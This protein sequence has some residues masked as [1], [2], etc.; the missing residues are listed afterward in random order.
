RRIRA[1][2]LGALPVPIVAMTADARVETKSRCLEAGMDDFVTKPIRRDDVEGIL[3]RWLPESVAPAHQPRTKAGPAAPERAIIDPD[4]IEALRQFGPSHGSAFV[5]SCIQTFLDE[6]HTLPAR[7]DDAIGRESWHD[8]A[9]LA[10]TTR[11][12]AMTVG[13]RDVVR[14]CQA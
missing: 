6:M 14:A 11:G 10:H 13:A 12:D 3:R 1:L 9:R 2:E 7:L 4:A 5:R 8:V